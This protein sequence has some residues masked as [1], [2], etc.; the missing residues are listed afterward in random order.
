MKFIINNEPQNRFNAGRP[1]LAMAMTGLLAVTVGC[2]DDHDH[3]HDHEEDAGTQTD[4]GTMTAPV[5]DSYEFE[6]RFNAGE[7]SLS[8]SGQITRH[9][10][11]KGLYDQMDKLVDD[12]NNQTL[13]AT[14]GSVV[15]RL[16]FFLDFDGAND[17]TTPHTISTTPP[18]KQKT[19]GDLSTST[20]LTN[21]IAGNDTKTDYKCWNPEKR[22]DCTVSEFAGWSL[23]GTT[24]PEGLVRT[25]FQLA[26]DNAIA[27]QSMTK[28]TDP[29][30][31]AI[32][33]YYVTAAGHDLKQLVQKFLLGAIAYH[34]GTDDYLHDDVDGKGLKA[35]NSEP[36]KMG[37]TYTGAEHAWDEGF[38][39]F[40]SARDYKAYTDDEIA[41]KGGRDG[42]KAGYHDTN[43]D[44]EIDLK[45]EYNFGHS[46]N[47][48]KRDRGSADGAKTDM[49]EKAINAFLKGRH[50]LATADGELSADEMELLKA[51]R[52]IIVASW[53]LA[54]A[55]T[56]LHYINDTLQDM[57]KVGTMDYD[58]YD[59]A[60]HWSELKGFAL[61][62]QFNPNKKIT[63]AQFVDLHNKIGDAPALP[64]SM[65]FDSYKADLIAARKILVD[66]YGIDAKNVG[67]DKGQNGW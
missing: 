55:S 19:Y 59:H 33:K 30:G 60:K 41:G 26:E 17:G 15:A 65:N 42:Y 35:G 24:T 62:L 52:D 43:A 46:V 56:A 34:Q 51:E 37:A 63:D 9:A 23:T 47:A 57:E 31:N 29:D 64:N 54:I 49:T 25:W 67:D 66:A 40:G 2:G 6:S 13:T 50:M 10:L 22:D 58:F 36:G 28:P 11:I 21:K 1:I 8:Y 45:S 38:G 39:Y 16:N 32:T 53:E 27:L 4:A 20:K 48:A 12:V 18:T 14:T 5:P 44:G 3:D 61:S 7:S